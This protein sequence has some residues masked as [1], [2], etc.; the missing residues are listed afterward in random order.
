MREEL[1]EVLGEP[2]TGASLELRDAV[3]KGNDIETG[4][5]VSVATQRRYP[6]VRGIP[7]FVDPSGYTDSFGMQWNRFREVQIDSA[8]K[9]GE[10]RRRFDAE[11]GWTADHLRGKWVL[12]AGC[13]AGRFSEIVASRGAKLVALDM[14][15]AVDATAKTLEG[16]GTFDVVQGSIL[17]PPL[18][19]ASVD[20]AFCIGVAQHTPSP[21]TAV[22][23]V[24]EAV[25]AGGEF[26]FSIYAR[27]P[28]TKLNA[29]YLIRPLTKRM[30]REL[31]LK[32]IEAV[33]PLAFPI[34]DRVFSLPAIGR[35]AHFIVPVAAYPA[36][37]RPGWTRE[38]RYQ[39]A[40]LDTFDML[41]PAYDQP[42]TWR[43]VET[44]VRAAGAS[45]W[46]FNTRVPVN[47]VGTR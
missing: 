41:S 45:R 24:V 19:K 18:K 44:A 12:D 1:L 16:K 9:G 15:S 47:C 43:E 37:E 13:G 11:T 29:K 36:S 21:M 3:G 32:S 10:S 6:I 40:V 42:M 35:V 8:T 26:A 31:L 4:T 25:K 2:L 20:F 46:S 23:S 14:S 17:E 22:Q 33:M 30:P 27:Q 28:W 39:E 7:R 38:H 5:L 34:V